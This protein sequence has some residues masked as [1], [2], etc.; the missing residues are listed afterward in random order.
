MEIPHSMKITCTTY[1]AEEN[2]SS[3]QKATLVPLSNRNAI[4]ANPG[5][6]A[7]KCLQSTVLVT[8][9]CDSCR[10]GCHTIQQR[11]VP[12]V[13]GGCITSIFRVTECASGGSWINMEEGRGPICRQQ[14]SPWAKVP[15]WSNTTS[16]LT[17][18]YIKVTHIICIHFP[19]KRAILGTPN[20][21]GLHDSLRCS[22]PFHS[23]V[24]QH[25]LHPTVP[26]YS[27][28]HKS[29]T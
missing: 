25:S 6:I 9:V 1:M 12:S 10:L 24:G 19:Q 15:G 17:P 13:S 16:L 27:S 8:T 21:H 28:I 7:V 4:E 11:S 14:G 3:G 26:N 5:L 23:S 22:S 20:T 18:T 2:Q 29:Q